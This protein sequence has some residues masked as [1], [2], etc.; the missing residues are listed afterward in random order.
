METKLLSRRTYVLMEFNRNRF[1]AERP[2]AYACK[3]CGEVAF[4][5]RLMSVKGYNE[6][7]IES[8]YDLLWVKT[9]YCVIC[10][11]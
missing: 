4:P 6:D 1:Y 11:N 3:E 2:M 8:I 7:L 10:M 9:P 5:I